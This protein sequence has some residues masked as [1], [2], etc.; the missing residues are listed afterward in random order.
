MNVMIYAFLITAGILLLALRWRVI[1]D[2]AI[3]WN[4]KVYRFEKYC[5]LHNL[6]ALDAKDNR[7]N[8]ATVLFVFLQIWKVRK[9]YFFDVCVDFKEMDELIQ[10]G[11][12]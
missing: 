5:L 6:Y 1:S 12:I 3:D 9:R 2:A 8:A 11:E 10:L 4:Y 7:V